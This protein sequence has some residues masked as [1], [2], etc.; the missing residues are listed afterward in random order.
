[1]IY[2]LIIGAIIAGLLWVR[3]APSD[4]ARWHVPVGEA[5]DVTGAGWAA[6]VIKARPGTLG[7]LHKAMLGLPRT[8]LLA[9]SMEARRLTYITRSRWI[10]FPDYTTIE[11]DGDY[12]KLYARLR[13]GSS[14]FGVNGARLDRLVAAVEAGG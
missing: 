13:F 2:A 7:K 10:G 5:E 9:G 14:D 11:Q 3:F 1:M 8:E 6:R 4:P 12:I